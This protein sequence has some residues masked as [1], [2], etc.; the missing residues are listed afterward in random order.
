MDNKY[1]K[2]IIKQCFLDPQVFLYVDERVFDINAF[3]D[4]NCKAYFQLYRH[5]SAEG[6][7][8][9]MTT[10]NDMLS[11]SGNEDLQVDFQK[12]VEGT[13]ADESEWKYHLTFILEI[14]RKQ[15]IAETTRE[16]REGMKNYSSSDLADVMRKG[17]DK[18][19]GTEVV[20]K[21]F[22][23]SM[24]G[25]IEEIE[26]IARGEKRSFLKTGWKTFDQTVG[27]SENKLIMVASQ[28]KIGKSRWMTSLCDGIIQNNDKIAVQWYTLEMLSAEVIRLF[29]SMRT[30]FTDEIMLGRNGMLK[31]E[32]ISKIEAAQE[33]I[34]GYPIEFIDE[35][36]TIFQLSSCYRRFCERNKGRH[37]I[38]IID[39]IGCITPHMNMSTE[40]EDDLSRKLKYLRDQTGSTIFAVH[41]LTKESE[42]K[43]NKN[44]S[45][46]PKITHIRG[47]SRLVD[48]A[49]Q[50]ILLHRPGHYPDILEEERLRDNEEYCKKLFIV[51]IA[52][53]RSGKTRQIAFDHELEC[54]KFTEQ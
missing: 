17:L 7:T 41:H 32:Q 33:N 22:R 36:V 2:N 45:Y 51:D 49:N 9:C 47:S 38:C 19:Q 31:P 40:F 34:K 54:C 26:T 30:R 29:I 46:E 39:N 37:C 27:I 12:T 25:A 24:Q 16:V 21:S 8:I 14:H 35:P 18:I 5:I 23:D 1:Q 3:T 53:N 43:F 15:I 4:N 13:Y 44:T 10:I 42:S 48:F 20:I 52:L 28:K 6:Q 11:I 50:V